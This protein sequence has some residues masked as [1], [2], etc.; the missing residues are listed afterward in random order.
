M[1]EEFDVTEYNK[2]M[3]RQNTVLAALIL[4]EFLKELSAIAQEHFILESFEFGG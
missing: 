3:K 4:E 2:V 1:S